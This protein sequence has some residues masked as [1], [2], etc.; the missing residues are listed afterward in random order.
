[1]SSACRFLDARDPSALTSAQLVHSK[2]SI[3]TEW[4]SRGGSTDGCEE[5]GD[6]EAGREEE[7]HE[8]EEQEVALS[9]S[10]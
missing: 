7:D 10:G 8:E 3:D 9:T 6:E 2:L 5:E 1:V 4:T